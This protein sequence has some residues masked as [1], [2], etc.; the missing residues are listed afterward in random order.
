MEQSPQ[1]DE[2]GNPLPVQPTLDP[3]LL[4]PEERNKLFWSMV[5]ARQKRG[6]DDQALA[7][8]ARIAL[9][10]EDRAQKIALEKERDRLQ[11]EI[12]RR[13]ENQS[14]APVIHRQLEQD[15][16][17]RPRVQA[18]VAFVPKKPALFEEVSE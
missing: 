13:L 3:S 16:V 15:R 8:L 4:K 5:R 9:W 11:S 7:L 10:E 17:V 18:G 12:A 1:Y 14:R 2:S 6:E